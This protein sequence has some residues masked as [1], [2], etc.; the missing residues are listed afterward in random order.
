M[1]DFALK[2]LSSLD[3]QGF[4]FALRLS[5]SSLVALMVATFLG[6]PNSYWAAMTVW[7]VAQRTRGL[8]MER[9]LYRLIGTGVG[10]AAGFILMA[11]SSNPFIV[12]SAILVF[13]VACVGLGNLVRGSRS[14]GVLLAGYTMA[15][16]VLPDIGD[17]SHPHDLAEARVVCTVIGVLVSMAMGGLFAPG[18]PREAFIARSRAAGFD[19]FI[20]VADLVSGNQK[21]SATDD[22]YLAVLERRLVQEIAEIEGMIDSVAAGSRDAHRRMRFLRVFLLEL[23][24][25]MALARNL[26]RRRV[27]TGGEGRE[28]ADSFRELAD[29]IRTGRDSRPAAGGLRGISERTC[30]I[31]QQDAPV[32]TALSS[33]ALHAVEALRDFKRDSSSLERVE[34][35]LH[36]DVPGAIRAA[37]RTAFGLGILAAGWFATGWS[38]GPFAM[39][40]ASIFLLVFS[41]M[42]HPERAARGALFGTLAG[43]AAA[44][45]CRGLLLPNADT[46]T[47]MIAMLFP[48][49]LV[50]SAAMAYPPTAKPA[51]DAGMSFFLVSQPILPLHGGIELGL[52]VGASMIVSLVVVILAFRYV[53]PSNPGARGRDIERAVVN[54]V[55]LMAMG[56]QEKETGRRLTRMLHRV[57]RLAGS[58][59]GSSL[60][61]VLAP[62]SLAHAIRLLEAEMAR[63]DQTSSVID[64]CGRVLAVLGASSDDSQAQDSLVATIASLHRLRAEP[65]IVAVVQDILDIVMLNP[66]LLRVR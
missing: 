53:L 42:P 23:V 45:L 58:K 32:L 56:R 18:S 25:V 38:G 31:V 51:I 11:V 49:I 52:S 19:A 60:E 39:M 50:G 1:P 33:S 2:F 24:N 7:I 26:T 28:L 20:W 41:T 34:L 44:L 57:L 36:R 54:D 59:R 4:Y 47:Q 66:Y 40:G 10:A 43:V 46:I 8:L 65:Q 16:V 5:A 35:A 29:T 13:A 55:R 3:R 22:H 17:L 6:I 63:S 48:F 62:V 27:V 37:I 15:I 61:A 30:A 14:Y 64:E 9:G 21:S 12:I